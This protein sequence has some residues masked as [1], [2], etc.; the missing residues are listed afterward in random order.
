MCS[1]TATEL[2]NNMCRSVSSIGAIFY[3]LFSL[4]AADWICP[5]GDKYCFQWINE[6]PRTWNETRARC[7]QI[8]GDLPGADHL[9]WNSNITE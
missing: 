2:S 4:A 6:P 8:G 3:F 9:V 1:T 7:A 5:V